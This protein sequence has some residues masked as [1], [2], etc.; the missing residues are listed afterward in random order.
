MLSKS[1]SHLDDIQTF[2]NNYYKAGHVTIEDI[3]DE[4]YGNPPID[5]HTI[6]IESVTDTNIL[7][8]FTFVKRQSDKWRLLK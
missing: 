3:C 7:V 1:D 6:E 2:I 8:R 5:I 4:G